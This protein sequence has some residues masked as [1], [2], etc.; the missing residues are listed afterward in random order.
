MLSFKMAFFQSCTVDVFVVNSIKLKRTAM[1]RE[2]AK[3]L[4]RL[5]LAQMLKEIGNKVYWLI[6]VTI[7]YRPLKNAIQSVLL[8]AME[9]TNIHIT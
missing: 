3:W 8:I 2:K 9:F 1:W 6:R 7:L 5:Y 4:Q